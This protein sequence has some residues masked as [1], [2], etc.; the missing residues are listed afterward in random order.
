[1]L[2]R[3]VE[4]VDDPTRRRASDQVAAS[5][6]Q[7]MDRDCQRRSGQSMGTMDARSGSSIGGYEAQ[8]ERH[9][10]SRVRG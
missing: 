6:A 8:G 9:P 4:P 2:Q 7:F 1:V 5:A 10:Q 3:C